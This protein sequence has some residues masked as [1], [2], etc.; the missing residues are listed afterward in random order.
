MDTPGRQDVRTVGGRYRL[1]EPLGSGGM[2]TVWRAEDAVLGRQ[3][4][5]K[6]VVFP[7]GLSDEDRENLR[8]RTRR[9]ARAAARLDHPSAVTVYDVVE[10]DGQP[11]LVLELVEAR[12]LAQVVRADGPLSVR[13]TAH[14]GLSLL[15]ALEAAHAQGIVHR[16]VKPSNVLLSPGPGGGPGRV[17]LTDFGIATSAGDPSITSTGLL[18]GSPSYISPERARGL[19][20]GPA[21]DLWSLG[22]T[23]F[24]AVEGRPPYDKGEPLPTLTAVVTGDQEPYVAAGPLVPV[25]D[26]LL[27]PDPDTRLSGAQARAL[28]QEVARIADEV[29]T[30]A[31]QPEPEAE[32]RALRTSALPI[33]P[34]VETLPRRP[35]RRSRRR[36]RPLTSPGR[37]PGRPPRRSSRPRRPP[38]PPLRRP[39]LRWTAP[40]RADPPR[41]PRP[42]AAAVRCSPRSAWSR[43]SAPAAW[44][45]RR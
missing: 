3:V 16:D 23:L 41:T 39:R 13:D 35:R 15:G 24:T 27:A 8:E 28:L 17:V 32:K 42:P 19:P 5:V 1:L 44:P 30:V 33:S 43:C 4:A 2:G 36:S 20:P 45:C 10:E 11:W 40:R 21:S 29:P 7:H 6:E 12:T 14:V 26:G 31:P 25:L 34:P 37:V 38:P 22:A 9:E 18:L